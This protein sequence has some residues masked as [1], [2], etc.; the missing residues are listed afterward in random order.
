[1]VGGGCT[2]GQIIGQSMQETGKAKR[3]RPTKA[4]GNGTY[5]SRR[6]KWNQ[7]ESVK[8]EMTKQKAAAEGYRKGWKGR[9]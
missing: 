1:M 8:R 3:Q 6:Q 9:T 4:K 5:D 7:K 2:S